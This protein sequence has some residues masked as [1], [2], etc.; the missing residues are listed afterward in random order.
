MPHD[1]DIVPEDVRARFRRCIEAH[2]GV[3]A[4]AALLGTS[5]ASIHTILSGYGNPGLDLAVTIA[6][7]FG[8]PPEAWV[9]AATRVS[10]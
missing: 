4:A 7:A 8:I 2:G 9:S 5:R 6:R 1:T 3:T 10:A